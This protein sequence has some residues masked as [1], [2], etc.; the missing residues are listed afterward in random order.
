MAR[1]PLTEADETNTLSGER[2]RSARFAK[3][4]RR[5]RRSNRPGNSQAKEPLAGQHSGKRSLRAPADGVSRCRI[6]GFDETLRPMTEGA[7]SVREPRRGAQLLGA[8]DEPARFR[9]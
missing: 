4:S 3:G 7:T 8:R 5:R 1:S 2:E 9:F 6:A